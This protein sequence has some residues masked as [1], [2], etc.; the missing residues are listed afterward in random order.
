MSVCRRLQKMPSE[1]STA[2]GSFWQR[3]KQS[4]TKCKDEEEEERIRNR[5]LCVTLSWC[6]LYTMAHQLLVRLYF[7]IYDAVVA[8]RHVLHTVCSLIPFICMLWL[9]VSLT[10]CLSEPFW[11]S[12]CRLLVFDE[13]KKWRW[14]FSVR[15]LCVWKCICQSLDEIQTHF[16]RHAIRC[17]RN[18]IW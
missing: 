5:I 14:W 3:Q 9:R 16:V 15:F 11:L 12:F 4:D 10:L 2:K 7:N 1:L 17:W 8:L 18:R 6:T 13:A